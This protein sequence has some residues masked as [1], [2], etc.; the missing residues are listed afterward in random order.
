M[1]DDIK[2]YG[3]LRFCPKCNNYLDPTNERSGSKLVFRCR[4]CG[5]VPIELKE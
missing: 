5:E 4:K 3:G 1:A 2:N